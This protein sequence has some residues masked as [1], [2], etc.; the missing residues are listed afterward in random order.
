MAPTSVAPLLPSQKTQ[1]TGPVLHALL[2]HL[3]NLQQTVIHGQV[4]TPPQPFISIGSA[5]PYHP[6]QFPNKMGKMYL[7]DF[8]PWIL[9]LNWFNSRYPELRHGKH[10]TAQPQARVGRVKLP[11]LVA[12]SYYTI[13]AVYIYMLSW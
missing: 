10:K 13:Q 6:I 7:K 2:P 3:H 8:S 11:S 5:I 4:T 9:K 12:G 1:G